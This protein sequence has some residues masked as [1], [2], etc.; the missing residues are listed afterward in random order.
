MTTS[1]ERIQQKWLKKTTQKGVQVKPVGGD[2]VTVAVRVRPLLTNTKG[3]PDG[4]G[5][6]TKAAIIGN[7]AINAVETSDGKTRKKDYPFDYVFTQDQHEIYD[8]MGKDMLVDAF[9]GYNVCL[10][11]Y[12]QTGSGK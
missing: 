7:T 4:E 8:C 6:M 1:Q 12:G 2:R 3:S 11:A 9:S 10:F 5:A